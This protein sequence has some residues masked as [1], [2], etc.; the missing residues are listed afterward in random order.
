M[1]SRWILHP[2][3]STLDNALGCQWRARWVGVHHILAC[4]I[5]PGLP[6]MHAAHSVK[7]TR[8]AQL[9]PRPHENA[10]VCFWRLVFLAESQW[11]EISNGSGSPPFFAPQRATM[12]AQANQS[13]CAHHFSGQLPARCAAR[14]VNLCCPHFLKNRCLLCCTEHKSLVEPIAGEP[15]V[16][17]FAMSSDQPTA[18]DGSIN[19]VTH[20]NVEGEGGELFE[21]SFKRPTLCHRSRFQREFRAA[22]IRLHFRLA[23]IRT[24]ASCDPSPPLHPPPP[25][26]ARPTK[27][28]IDGERDAWDNKCS[29]ASS[30]TRAVYP[31]SVSRSKRGF[32]FGAIAP[33]VTSDKLVPTYKMKR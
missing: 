12:S 33:T 7:P 2:P 15:A 31:G 17:G 21:H 26:R 24:L 5:L 13:S 18:S 1:D 28:G 6:V 3:M 4:N 16:G 32:H 23:C 10:V 30:N 8:V 19:V 27:T 29:Y 20:P 25:P 11:L 22:A 9:D 14:R